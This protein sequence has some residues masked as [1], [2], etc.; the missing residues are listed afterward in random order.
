[1]TTNTTLWTRLRSALVEPAALPA[2]AADRRAWLTGPRLAALAAVTGVALIAGY[3]VKALGGPTGL[4]WGVVVVGLLTGSVSGG[5]K[6]WES[7]A[8]GKL[9]IDVLMILAAWGAAAIGAPAEGLVL[10]FLFT[11]S[12]ALQQFA[13]GR[14]QRAIRGLMALRPDVARRRLPNGDVA[15]VPVG[16][17]AVG[18]TIVVQPGE[19]IPADGTVTAG[20]SDVDASALTGESIPVGKAPGDAVF[21][22]FALLA[23]EDEVLL[24]RP[25]EERRAA[26]EALVAPPV[27]LTPMVRTAA[28]AER[29]LHEAEGVMAKELAAP[30]RPGKRDGM[31]K[32]K[33]VRTIDAVVMGWRPGKAEGTV[34]ALILGLYEPD[35]RLR[36]VGHSSGF[37]AK[38]K[39]ELVETLRPYET[40]E[41]GSAEPS[42]W[43][44]GRD[45]QWVA[46]RPELVVE[47]TF[48]HTSAGR[49][50]HGAKV[51]RWREDKPPATCLVEQ[52]D[53]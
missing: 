46:L 16:Q 27:E 20:A 6:A 28:A 38:E 23:R 17:L 32:I 47:I 33:R 26:I 7:I 51:R 41:R 21:A 40:G 35:G 18:D 19:R 31:V 3:A 15:W 29:W 39:R 50:R 22:A 45:L 49:I 10:L 44:A 25:Y 14:T 34:G 53:S 11:L 43:T 52:L 42:R 24:E 48:D 12:E 4:W 30:Y 37:T 8:V 1:M 5:F 2:P 9:N 36:E 13:M